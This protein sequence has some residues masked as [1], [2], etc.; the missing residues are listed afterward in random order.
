MR[1]GKSTKDK[2]I[3]VA[4]QIFAQKGYEGTTLDE[5]AKLCNITKPAIY[6]HFKDKASLYEYILCSQFEEMAKRVL[7]NTQDGTVEDRLRAYIKS[8]GQY[9]IDNPT[10]SSIFSR[11]ISI[12]G[13]T[14]PD[15]CIE[16]LSKTL[17]RLSDILN[18]G[19]KEGIFKE[20][21]PFLVQMMIVTPL[22]AYHASKPLRERVAKS[23]DNRYLNIEFTDIVD[24]LAN[25]ILSALKI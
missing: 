17:N 6:Y 8:F 13:Q 14:L 23:I 3:S 12:G 16:E 22:S 20:V 25:K 18:D 2:I 11:E 5:I 15:G 10:F 21:N 7:H 4:M 9:L 19:I 1:D 24:N